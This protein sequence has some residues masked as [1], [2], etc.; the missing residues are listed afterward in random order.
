MARTL[1]QIR[2]RFAA[3][4][5][6]CERVTGALSL[7]SNKTRFRILCVL[8]EGDFCVTDIAEAVQMGKLSNISQQLRVLSLA[9]IVEKTREQQHVIY[10]LKDRRVAELI[11]VLEKAFAQETHS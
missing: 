4:E 11:K 10:R 5:A 3:N 1:E 7:M 9:G 2:K 8:A 6:V